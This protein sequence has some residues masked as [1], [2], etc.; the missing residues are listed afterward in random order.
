M[1]F[2]TQNILQNQIQIVFCVPQNK[3]SHNGL[4]KH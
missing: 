4:E 2:R 3:E 1:L